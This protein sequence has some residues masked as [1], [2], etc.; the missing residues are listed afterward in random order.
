MRKN[1]AGFI[2]DFVVKMSDQKNKARAAT[3]NYINKVPPP[4][5]FH[6]TVH[7][8]ICFAYSDIDTAA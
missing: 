3:D 8:R 4:P 5:Q 6:L 2:L 7:K 1:L